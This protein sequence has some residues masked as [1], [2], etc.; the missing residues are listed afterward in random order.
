MDDFYRVPTLTLLGILVAVF[1]A[2]YAR[3]RTPRRLLWL[4]GWTM[5]VV[6]LCM[7]AS[8]FGQT[9]IGQAISNSSMVLAALM[10]LESL[11]PVVIVRRLRISYV[12]LSA[13]PPVF[14]AASVALDPSPGRFLHLLNLLAAVA[15]VGVAIHWSS[16]IQLL[17]VWFTVPWSIAI[18]LPCIYLASTGSNELC[19]RLAQSGISFVT[20]LLVLAAYRR[21]SPGVIFTASGFFVWSLPLLIE[22]VRPGAEPAWTLTIRLLNLMRVITAVGMIVLVLEDEARENEAAQVRDRRARAEMVE[23]A[24]LDLSVE[25]HHDFGIQYSDVCNTIARASRFRQSVIFLLNVER[26]LRVAASA[27]VDAALAATLDLLGRRLT[28][29]ELEKIW[30]HSQSATLPAGGLSKVDLQPWIQPGDELELQNFT[31]AYTLPITTRSGDLQGLLMLAGLKDGKEALLPEDLLPLE[32]LVSRMAAAREN[33]LLS[34]RITQTEKLAG[35]GQ[36]AGGVAHELNNP[37][38][39]VMGYAELI[40]EGSAEERIR[41]DAGIIRSEAHRMKQIV[42]SLARFWK[43]SPSPVAPV[44]VPELLAEVE[45]LRR[46]EYKRV[47]IELDLVVA[48]GLPSIRANSDQMR[49]VLLQVMDN[50]AAAVGDVECSGEKQIRIEATRSGDQ[51]QILV[52]DSGAGFPNPDRVF[53]PFFTPTTPGESPGLALS[54]C[55]SIV[56]EQGGDMSALNLHP[57]GA[58]VV[59]EMPG[60]AVHSSIGQSGEAIAD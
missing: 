15:T 14:F 11:S 58:V 52:S 39:V 26:S 35:I 4:I 36:L 18:G 9:G 46:R 50:A 37:L 53:D 31:S 59:I 20:A 25:P 13:I 2:L 30:C 10:F 54:L 22:A 57:H 27:G 40:Q 3:S 47:G 38:T 60:E 5:A 7:Q 6:R 51:I 43:P 28:V 33:G 17:P 29:D 1:A 34:R 8:K 45:S 19:L 44:S 49:Q 32:L 12:A 55:Y 24:K 16:R 42:E 48:E 21:L 41:R 23:Y 56:R